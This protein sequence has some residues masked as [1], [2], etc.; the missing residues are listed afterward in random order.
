MFAEVGVARR[1]PHVLALPRIH[2]VIAVDTDSG[3]EHWRFDPRAN[4]PDWQ[5][6]RGVAYHRPPAEAPP[7]A[8]R[9]TP[10]SASPACARCKDRFM[11]LFGIP[12]Q[13]PPFGTVSAIDLR[14]GRLA[15]QVPMGTVRDT[16]PMGVKM[17]LPTPVG[18][19]ASAGPSPRR[20]A[21]SS[22]PAARTIACA[23]SMWRRARSKGRLP[24]GPQTG[25]LDDVPLAEDRPAICPDQRGRGERR[26]MATTM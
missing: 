17:G 13:K 21:W 18:L 5:R 16:G 26:R 8:P 23:P 3:R 7:P 19:P 22:S 12:C 6:C 10:A 25:D 1:A 20:A 14:S 9:T 24:V 2:T 4:S 11:S 15:W